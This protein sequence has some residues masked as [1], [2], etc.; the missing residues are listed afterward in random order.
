MC[1]GRA[2]FIK[3]YP[4]HLRHLA[5]LHAVVEDRGVSSTQPRERSAKAVGEVDGWVMIAGVGGIAWRQEHPSAHVN[6]ASPEAGERRAN[7]IDWLSRCVD[8]GILREGIWRLGK[9][10]AQCQTRR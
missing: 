7:E 10:L 6:V 5:V 2:A 9:L 3:Q 8:F 1:A 4:D